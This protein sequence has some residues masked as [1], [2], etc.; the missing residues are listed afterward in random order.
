MKQKISYIDEEDISNKRILLRADFDVALDAHNL[1]ADDFRIRQRIPT[2]QYLLKKKNR[3]ICVSKLGRPKDREPRLSMKIVAQR[4][5]RYLPDYKIHLVND[6]LTE[7]PATFTEQKPNEILVLENIRFYPEEKQNDKEFA[8][9]LASCAD[10][11]VNDAFAMCHRTESSVVGVPQLLPSYAGLQLKKEIAM[12]TKAIE[13]PKKPLVVI[14]GGAKISTKIS[15]ISRLIEIADYVI[16]GGGLAN[17]FF[18]AQRYL[19][20]SSICEYEMTLKARQLL[21]L[22]EQKKTKIILPT[23]VLIGNPKDT[24][25]RGEVVRVQENKIPKNKAILDI[26]PETKARY[27]SYIARAGTIIWNGPVGLFENPA[28]RN[29]TDFIYYAIAHNPE[30]ISIVGGGDT[31]SAISKEEYLKT[32][33]HVSTGGG[34]ML[35]FIEKGTLPGIEALR[36]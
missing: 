19:I 11:Y 32:I 9:K 35:E 24:E 18:R 36:H 22:A 30:A 13:K 6:F 12:I 20:G 8:K 27:G 26:G 34:A 10:V 4:L 28:Y 5:G 2:L 33:T 14:I 15:L 16:L 21:Y 29:G 1:I 25:K 23:D 7:D 31:I 17:V 3:I